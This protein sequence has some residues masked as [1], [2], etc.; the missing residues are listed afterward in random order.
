[1]PK[2][3]VIIP[4][5][6]CAKYIGEAIDSVLAQTFTDWELIIVD[7]GSTD[8]TKE[9]IAPYLK[10]ER[11][12]YVYQENRGVSSARNKGLDLANGE[13]VAFLDAD[14]VWFEN[15]LEDKIFAMEKYG[16]DVIFSD[17]VFETT[18]ER[19]IFLQNRLP[20][21]WHKKYSDKCLEDNFFAL[22]EN[23]ILLCFEYF[24]PIHTNMVVLKRDIFKVF[25]SFDE[26]FKI[27]EDV[28]MWH[29]ILFCKIGFINKTYGV[30]R[31]KD[32]ITSNEL[33]L[34]RSS[35]RFLRKLLRDSKFKEYNA[36]INKKLS[37]S[38]EWIADY[39]I[40]KNREIYRRRICFFLKRSIQAHLCNIWA[41]RSFIRR[42]FF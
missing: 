33:K 28:D 26:G 37:S 24:H 18:N 41:W 8:N 13:Y 38:L 2:V 42:C 20:K 32:G 30:Y 39:Y 10:D 3:S 23:F 12:R 40:R 11:I 17:Y 34:L 15:N 22:G 5:Y 7:D 31:K 36:Y 6:N 1:M 16:F 35:L 4:T 19:V 29:R 21:D 27:G 9:V 25:G 14:D